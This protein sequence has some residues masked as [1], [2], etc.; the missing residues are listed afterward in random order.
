MPSA[1]VQFLA[2]KGAKIDMWNHP[3][4]R[5]WT[6]LTIARG[7]RFGNYKPSVVTVAAFHEVMKKAGIEIPPPTVLPPTKDYVQD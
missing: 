6:P 5:G 2:D 3:N 1:I 4:R 7:H